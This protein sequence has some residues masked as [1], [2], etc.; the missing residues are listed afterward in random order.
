MAS[1]GMKSAKWTW[2]IK[3]CKMRVNLNMMIDF[4]SKI[5][6]SGG[7]DCLINV[8][9]IFDK[10]YCLTRLYWHCEK[11]V[12]HNKCYIANF[13]MKSNVVEISFFFYSSW[14]KKIN[15]MVKM[16]RFNM[17]SIWMLKKL[18]ST[19]CLFRQFNALNQL[20]TLGIMVPPVGLWGLSNP[21]SK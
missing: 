3:N 13:W 5:P 1:L 18:A 4:K 17:I 16:K 6:K 12:L 8:F 21:K 14:G 9:S 20:L 7:T 2:E 11:R 15:L 19:V 10:G